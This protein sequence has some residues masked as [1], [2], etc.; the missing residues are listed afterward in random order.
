MGPGLRASL[1]LSGE[2]EQEPTFR[3]NLP[4]EALNNMDDRGVES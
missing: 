4:F 2:F 1:Y 3:E